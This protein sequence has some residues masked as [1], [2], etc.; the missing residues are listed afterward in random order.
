MGNAMAD[1]VTRLKRL[2]LFAGAV[3]SANAGFINA[4]FLVALFNPVSHVT[5]SLSNVGASV[6]A[7]GVK[8]V[9]DLVMIVLAFFGGATAA[10][11]MLRRPLATGRRYGAALLIQSAFLG[12]A[13]VL[14][15]EEFVVLGAAMGAAATGL[16][17]GMSSNYRGV[18]LRT[19]HMT[20]TLTDLGVFIGRKGHR[21]SDRWKGGLLLITLVMFVLGGVLGGVGASRE[22]IHALWVPAVCCAALGLVYVLYRHRQ[23]VILASGETGSVSD[24]GHESGCPAA[25]GAR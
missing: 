2:A 3:L 7:G 4:A 13:P 1:G 24:S 25:S 10:G 22:D 6:F 17:N 9:R 18:A 12:V 21:G 11:A 15:A 8:G 23:Q 5:G 19:S 14:V 20:G 16:Q